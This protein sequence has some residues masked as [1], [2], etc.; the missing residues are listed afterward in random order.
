MSATVQPPQLIL[1]RLR[2][3]HATSD[4]FSSAELRKI[5]LDNVCFGNGVLSYLVFGAAGFG[6]A[7]LEKC[8]HLTSGETVVG[9]F[10]SLFVIGGLMYTLMG[11]WFNVMSHETAFERVQSWAFAHA[12]RQPGARLGRLV[13]PVLIVGALIAAA[14]TLPDKSR[15]EAE[16][17]QAVTAAINNAHPQNGDQAI[18]TAAAW[19]LN[20]TFKNDSS[21]SYI[22]VLDY[23]YQKFGVFSV[24][25]DKKGVLVSIGAF[26]QVYARDLSGAVHK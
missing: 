12:P 21:V 10:I 4:Q 16:I 24:V 2:D 23:R 20:T 8:A 22:D 19:L 3:V 15:H 11:C 7:A 14:S 17:R 6:A 25:T 1:A 18:S 26:N 5:Y 9:F 13:I